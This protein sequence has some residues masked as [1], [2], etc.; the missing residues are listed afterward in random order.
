[1]TWANPKQVKCIYTNKGIHWTGRGNW[2]FSWFETICVYVCVNI[3]TVYIYSIYITP[4]LTPNS[5]CSVALL[6]AAMAAIAYTSR[7]T[8]LQFQNHNYAFSIACPRTFSELHLLRVSTSKLQKHEVACQKACVCLLEN[9]CSI[10]SRMHLCHTLINTTIC[11]HKH[12]RALPM[13]QLCFVRHTIVR[14]VCGVVQ[15]Y[16][17]AF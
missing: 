8:M 16:K 11:V 7:N 17:H 9:I 10:F 15:Q 5:N 2:A 6:S 3:Y 4:A 14:L 13:S 1:M 12:D